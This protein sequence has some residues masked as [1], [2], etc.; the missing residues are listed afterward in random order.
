M[1]KKT[2][3]TVENTHK[4][5]LSVDTKTPWG[6]V[7]KPIPR[8]KSTEKSEK[9]DVL[10]SDMTEIEPLESSK[11]SFKRVTVKERQ[12]QLHQADRLTPLVEAELIPVIKVEVRP[13]EK[14]YITS[15]VTRFGKISKSLAIF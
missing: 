14:R 15:S 2:I 4:P 1:V 3:K 7:L 13:T 5:F 10:V 8:G 9:T 11:V 12:Q 6:V